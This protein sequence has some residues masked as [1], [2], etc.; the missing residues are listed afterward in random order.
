M[1]LIY[2]YVEEYKN[3]KDQGFNFSSKYNCTYKDN[4]L[5]IDKNKDYID[6]FFGDNINISA[7]VG[8]NGSGKS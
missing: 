8:K 7:I 1:E 6:N 4:T 3:I 5:T 2:L